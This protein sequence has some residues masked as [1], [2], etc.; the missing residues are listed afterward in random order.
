MFVVVGIVTMVAVVGVGGTFRSGESTVHVRYMVLMM[1]SRHSMVLG[2]N[3]PG[4]GGGREKRWEK[5]WE[6]GQGGESGEEVEEG[7]E[8][9]VRMQKYG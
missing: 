2:S 9:W 6:E 3:S 5:R 7:K 8:K 4:G 1:P